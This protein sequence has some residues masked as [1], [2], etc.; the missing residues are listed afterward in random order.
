ME[1]GRSRTTIGQTIM[2]LLTT[3]FVLVFSSLVFSQ[4]ISAPHDPAITS[5]KSTV[6]PSDAVDTKKNKATKNAKKSGTTS[7]DKKKIRSKPPKTK[8]TADADNDKKT[9]R[10]VKHT[11][12]VAHTSSHKDAPTRQ[13]TPK[14][15]K[16]FSRSQ[17]TLTLT[18]KTPKRG[19]AARMD[20]EKSTATR[21]TRNRKDDVD[22]PR[23]LTLSAAHKLRSQRAKVT[24]LNKLMSQIGKPYHWGGSSPYTGFDCSGLVYY[25]YK[26]IVKIP[27][28]RTANEMFHLRD[29][30]PIKKNELESGD[31]V[32]FR[33]NHRGTADHVGVYVGNGRFIQSPRAGSDIK[34]SKLNED[35]WQEHYIGARRVVMPQ[36]VR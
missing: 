32:F 20:E 34:L 23:G 25:A 5:R 13:P 36:T 9:K 8:T 21:V 12:T 11:P 6:D 7:Q 24:A 22:E 17:S 3:F 4:A 26:D 28:P 31:L 27:I 15:V 30:A 29:A 19:H 2:R 18:K 16:R 14:T 33:I 1:I 35:Y 10:S